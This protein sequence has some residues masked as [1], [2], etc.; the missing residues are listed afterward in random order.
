MKFVDGSKQRG[1]KVGIYE[2]RNSLN[3]MW[4]FET[5]AVQRE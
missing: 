5:A 2:D 3:Q 4:T 1:A